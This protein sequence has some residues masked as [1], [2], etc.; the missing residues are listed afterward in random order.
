MIRSTIVLWSLVVVFLCPASLWSQGSDNVRVADISALRELEEPEPIGIRAVYLLK[1]DAKRRAEQKVWE[2]YANA[3]QDWILDRE[4]P[5]PE[6]EGTIAPRFEE[7]LAARTKLAEA[8]HEDRRRVGKSH[9]KYSAELQQV[10][11][12]DFFEEYVF[13]T[14]HEEG[15]EAG[16]RELKLDDYKAWAAENIPDHEPLTYAYRVARALNRT[17]AV[18]IIIDSELETASEG[19]FWLRYSMARFKYRDDEGLPYDLLIGEEAIP[20]F[21]E[22]VAGRTALLKDF[23]DIQDSLCE[24]TRVATEEMAKA[25]AEGY[26]KE[27]VWQYLHHDGW[28]KPEDLKL[29]EFKEWSA[30]EIPNHKAPTHA[31]LMGRPSN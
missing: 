4:I 22:E 6:T 27:Y 11:E 30:K 15:W 9:R 23:E 21:E 20:S 2:I 28:E 10:I 31:I 16:D 24:A 29:E 18:M 8:L 5:L 7:E 13:L 3:R 17:K 19:A 26:M 1:A 12:A 14:H 25:E